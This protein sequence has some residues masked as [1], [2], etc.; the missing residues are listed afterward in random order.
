MLILQELK[1]LPG[2]LLKLVRN[3]FI[4]L[5]LSCYILIALSDGL[6]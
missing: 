3:D 4:L 6:A 2:E 1:E 5:K